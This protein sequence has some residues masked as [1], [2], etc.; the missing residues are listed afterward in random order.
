MPARVRAFCLAVEADI[1]RPI[2]GAIQPN[3]EEV[4]VK[5]QKRNGA[6]SVPCPHCGANSRGLLTQ[7]LNG[8]VYRVRQCRR[9]GRI[10][11]FRTREVV[12]GGPLYRVRQS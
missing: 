11:R 5:K 3:P 1:K 7:R 10:H 2:K 6:A 8:V 4:S 9:R 12:T